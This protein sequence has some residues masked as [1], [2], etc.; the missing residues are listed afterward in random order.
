MTSRRPVRHAHS[1][2]R[3][4][5]VTV[6]NGGQRRME[7]V[8]AGTAIVAIERALANWTAATGTQKADSVDCWEV[9]E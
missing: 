3:T 6:A 7:L 1:R 5:C 4:W 2:E 9:K 8:L